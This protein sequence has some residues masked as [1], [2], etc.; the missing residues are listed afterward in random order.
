MNIIKSFNS[1]ID[2]LETVLKE[3]LTEKELAEY[4]KEDFVLLIQGSTW[5]SDQGYA[6][7]AED[8]K[9]IYKKIIGK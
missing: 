2:Y 7:L 4:V 1:T 5:R 9:E 8:I 3:V 6:K